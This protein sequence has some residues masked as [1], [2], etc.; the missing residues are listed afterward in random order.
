MHKTKPH[1]GLRKRVRVTAT[2]KVIRKSS[3]GKKKMSGKSG[4]RKQRLRRDKPI[5]GQLAEH[6]LRAL[7]A[8]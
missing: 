2:G 4:R 8:E 5:L 6:C 7:V 3:H 1:K